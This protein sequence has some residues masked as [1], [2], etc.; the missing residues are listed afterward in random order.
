ML[1]Q[2]KVQAVNLLLVIFTQVI[3][4]A[5]RSKEEKCVA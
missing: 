3:Q 1:F 5:V 2:Q 4:I